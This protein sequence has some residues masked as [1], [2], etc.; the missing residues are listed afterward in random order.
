MGRELV[1]FKFRV[2]QGSTYMHEGAK[3][4]TVHEQDGEVFVWALVDPAAPMKLRKL[5][6]LGTGF[7]VNDDVME[8]MTFV[9]EKIG[10]KILSV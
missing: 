7:A 2:K 8:N 6:V 10:G 9:A 3:L 4:L 1:V 5:E